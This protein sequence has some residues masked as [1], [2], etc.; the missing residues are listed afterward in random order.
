MNSP[1]SDRNYFSSY[2]LIIISACLLLIIVVTD[3]RD[4]TSAALVISATILFLT[5]IFLFTISKKELIDDHISALIPVQNQINICII[6]SQLGVKGN[7]WFIPGDRSDM[8]QVTQFIPVSTYRGGMLEGD[9]FVS[10]YGGTGIIL[11]P[12]GETLLFDLRNRSNLIIPD[13]IDEIFVLIKMV[14]EE[15]LEISESVHV[16]KTG[17][18]ML[19]VME[20]YLLIDG[21]RRVISESPACCLMNPCPICSLFGMLITQGLNRAVMLERCR[22]GKNDARVEI[23]FTIESD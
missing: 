11:P 10:G 18:G 6:A 7:S 2:L 1:F 21:C 23:L 8:S 19:I 13:S 20:N 17:E 22:P 3:R 12:S 5:G 14:G 9:T 4:I 16:R 15:L